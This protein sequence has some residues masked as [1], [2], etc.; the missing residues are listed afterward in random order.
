MEVANLEDV[1]TMAFGPVPSRRLGK[2]LGI[3]NIPPKTCSYSCVYCQLGK[4]TN[5]TTERQIFYRSEDILKEVRKKVDATASRKEKVNYLTFVPD[6]EPT[7]DLNLGK[8]IS[9]LKQIGIPIAVLTNASL[10]WRDDV[11]EDLMK[12]N[13]VSLK[14]DAITEDLW[15]RINRPHEN[16][17]LNTIL[18]GIK[19]F[20][21]EFNVKVISETMFV[22]GINYGDEIEKIADFLNQL[23]RL[24]KTYIAVPARSPT[25]KW[26]KPPKEETINTAFQV[27]SKKL[28]TDS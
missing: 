1:E 2:S 5:M 6:G 4:T 19:E 10:I 14:V 8:E 15:M 16:L 27:F 25:G 24:D 17:R 28:G 23:E 26:V 20:A 21:N 11:K 9:I 3:N 18:E 12:A 13:L 7:L 22:D